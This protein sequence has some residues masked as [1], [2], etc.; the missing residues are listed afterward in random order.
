MPGFEII[1][2]VLYRNP[3]IDKARRAAYAVRM[4]LDDAFNDDRLNTR[5]VLCDGSNCHRRIIPAFVEMNTII[6]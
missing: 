5:F 6:N 3:S 2:E 1:E 4:D